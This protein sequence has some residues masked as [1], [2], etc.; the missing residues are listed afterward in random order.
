M[1]VKDIKNIVNKLELKKYEDTKQ[2]EVTAK[3]DMPNFVNVVNDIVKS[4]T[5][6]KPAWKTAFST[7]E[8]FN[9]YKKELTEELFANKVTMKQVEKGISR[10][11]SDVS[12][13][14]PSIGQF[15]RW[16][17]YSEHD[18]IA[19][20]FTRLLNN[21]KPKNDIEQAA[22]RVVGYECRT[23]LP[24]AI[25]FKRFKDEYQRLEKMKQQGI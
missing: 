11:R 9:A 22:W 12:P 4:L 23:R 20:A 24:Q 6:I 16:C 14:L 2:D 25:A 13:Y 10:A 7:K 18:D 3:N 5:A 21:G 1:A 19:E 8:Q 15:V 17:C